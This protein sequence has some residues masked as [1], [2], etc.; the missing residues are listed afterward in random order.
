MISEN[1]Q[2]A[3][4]AM[5][6]VDEKAKEAALERRRKEAESQ[7][8]LVAVKGGFIIQRPDPDYRGEP[9]REVVGSVDALVATVQRWAKERTER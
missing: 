9:E 5:G 2:L 1:V 8:Y 3:G 4:M 7:L 6:M